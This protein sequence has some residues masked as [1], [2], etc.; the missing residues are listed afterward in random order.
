[1]QRLD[2]KPFALLGVNTDGDRQEAKK[3][4]AENGVTWRSWWDGGT[5]RGPIVTQWNVHG[6]PSLYVL[7]GKGV[8][9]YK[10]DNLRG[11][12]L[13]NS[14]TGAQI[15]RNLDLAVDGLMSEVDSTFVTKLRSTTTTQ[16]PFLQPIPCMAV[17]AIV[18]IGT[19]LLL[20][21]RRLRRV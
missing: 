7:D 19:I 15:V 5:T 6:F 20:C 3:H 16:S 4:I 13:A 10:G 9:R 11:F 12:H 21:L 18:V 17:G 2:G 8:I 1:V 14:G